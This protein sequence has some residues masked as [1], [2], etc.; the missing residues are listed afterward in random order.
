MDLTVP[1][2]HNSE[3]TFAID[4]FAGQLDGPEVDRAAGPLAY[5]A[6]ADRTWQ[7]L[8]HMIVLPENALALEPHLAATQLT[9]VPWPVFS[10]SDQQPGKPLTGDRERGVRLGQHCSLKLAV[11]LKFEGAGCE[12]ILSRDEDRCR[13]GGQC[14]TCDHDSPHDLLDA[15]RD[16]Q[17]TY[18]EFRLSVHVESPKAPLSCREVVATGGRIP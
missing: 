3:V 15:G 5:S 8:D 16:R 9:K 6:N 7:E 1:R 2:V 17:I 4:D 11:L 14:P 18:V 13:G 10:W 12:G